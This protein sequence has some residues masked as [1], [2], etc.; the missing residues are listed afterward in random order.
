[1]TGEFDA[2]VPLAQQQTGMCPKPGLLPFFNLIGNRLAFPTTRH[3]VISNFRFKSS[4]VA[5]SQY[6][7]AVA[8]GCAAKIQP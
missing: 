8:G 4:M 3:N 2:R 7:R 6:H 1:M 5:S